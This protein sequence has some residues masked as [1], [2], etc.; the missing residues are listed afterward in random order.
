MA[1]EW[2]QGTYIPENKSKW[3]FPGGKYPTF[4]SSW[5]RRFMTWMDS[6]ASVIE[7]SSEPFSIEYRDLSSE[8]QP[9]RRYFPDFCMSVKDLNGRVAKYVVEIKP[10]SQCPLY[11][12]DGKLILP[13]KPK[14]QT[15]KAM[16][17]WNAKAR[18]ILMNHS[19]WMAARAFCKARGWA[20]KVITEDCVF[21]RA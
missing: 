7:A 11:A 12:T 20:F 6:S 10:K 16:A 21:N 19:K 5:E 14:K 17:N 15:S 13:P 3:R 18:T 4:R 1:D 2:S 8:G 9:I